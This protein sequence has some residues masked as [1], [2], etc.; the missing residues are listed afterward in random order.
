MKISRRVSIALLLLNLVVAGMIFAEDR[1]DEKEGRYLALGD[2]LAFGYII[3]AG[4]EYVNPEN[5][6]SYADYTARALRLD[7]VNASCPGETS[8]SFLSS[9]A[10][11]LGCRAIRATFPLHVAYGSTQLDFA[12]SYLKAHP[13]TQLVT[14]DL[15]ANDF[16]LLQTNC[17]QTTNPAQC[18][19][20]GFPGV[21]GMIELNMETILGELRATGYKGVIV[22]ANYYSLDFSDPQ[23]NQ[24]SAAV[25]AV[26]ANAASAHGAVIADVFSAFKNALPTTLTGDN[27]TCKAGLLNAT[28]Q[29]QFVCDIHATQSGHRLMARATVSAYAAAREKS[30]DRD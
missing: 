11:D 18:I 19:Q 22:V 20:S 21:L 5:F 4:F 9:S 2:S 28:P 16:F 26:L 1:G 24:L 17:A 25:N 8:S 7:V 10:P 27:W 30:K 15:G 14:I 23:Q 3:Q 6:V 12:I 13:H 29:N